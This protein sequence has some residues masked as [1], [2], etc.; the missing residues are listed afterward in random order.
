MAT[1]WKL[2]ESAVL[3]V[4]EGGRSLGGFLLGGPLKAPFLGAPRG[5]IAILP[6]LEAELEC[7]WALGFFGAVLSGLHTFSYD[8]RSSEVM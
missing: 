8:G 7:T 5:T 3:A 1:A 2:E 4:R 6:L